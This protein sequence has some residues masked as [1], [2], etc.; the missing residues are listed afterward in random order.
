[1]ND[2]KN[3]RG[4]VEVFISRDF[5]NSLVSVLSNFIKADG[6]NKYGVY[7]QLLK[8]KILRHGRKFSHNGEENVAVYFYENEA[9]MLIKLFAIYINAIENPADDYFFQVGKKQK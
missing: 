8:E 2:R 9:A 6:T 1:M 5:F 3:K 4:E 7:A